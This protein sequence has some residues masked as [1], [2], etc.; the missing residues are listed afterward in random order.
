YI[1]LNTDGR[2][3]K[4]VL[5]FARKN[6]SNLYIIVV[7]LHLAELSKAQGKE[8][9]DIDWKDTGIVLP[10][11][12]S[13]EIENVLIGKKFKERIRVKDLFT[14]FPVALL[15]TQV[16]EHQRAAGILLHIS[17]LP[18]PFGIGDMG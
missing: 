16:E 14:Q 3:K 4:N 2:Y 17:S 5:A 9:N 6:K 15:K 7:P 8:I 18:S 13:G 1:P 10:G 12:L 11:K